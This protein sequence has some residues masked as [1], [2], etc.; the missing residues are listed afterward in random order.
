VGSDFKPKGETLGLIDDAVGIAKLADKDGAELRA[1]LG[2]ERARRSRHGR[3][4]LGEGYL[5]PAGE[6]RRRQGRAPSKRGGLWFDGPL[7]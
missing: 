3:R 1:M 5:S 6:G 2:Q 7:R 4:T